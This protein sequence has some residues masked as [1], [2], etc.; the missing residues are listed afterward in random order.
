MVCTNAHSC[1]LV[2]YH[3]ESESGNF[4]LI[5][6][7]DLLMDM[8][9]YVCDSILCNEIVLDW[10]YNETTQLKNIGKKI[11]GKRL[12]FDL[13]KPVRTHIRTCTKSIVSVKFVDI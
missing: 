3:P 7:D 4:F 9:K 2:S 13:L 5:K 1:I 12:E 8:I 6:R 10:Y 11:L